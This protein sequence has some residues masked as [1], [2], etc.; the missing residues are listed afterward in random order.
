[1]SFLNTAV[2]GMIFILFCG[3]RYMVEAG[4]FARKNWVWIVLGLI[5]IFAFVLR[6]WGLGMPNLWFDESISA[7]NARDI[8][9]KGIPVFDS[10]ALYGGYYVFHYIMA[11]FYAV[12]GGDFSVRLISVLFG[13]ATVVLAFFIGKEFDNSSC[14]G[15]VTG[16]V[17]ALL[18]AV[19]YLEVVYSRQARFYQMFQFLFF[20][21]LLFLYKSKDEKKYA[22]LSCLSLI[23]LLD[24]HISG[25]V[26][27]PFFLVVFF[28][29][30]RKDEDWK[31]KDWILFVIPVLAGLWFG[32]GFFNLPFADSGSGLAGVNLESY[33]DVL[34][35]KLRAFFFISLI[36][37][38]F[39]IRKNLRMFL[40][41]VLPS[42]ILLIGLLFLKTYAIRYAYFSV[43]AVIILMAVLL[44]FIYNHSRVF[45]VIALVFILI[46]PSNLVYNDGFL[47]VIKPGIVETKS[48]TEPVLDY[49]NINSDALDLIME[50]KVVVMSTPGFYWYIKKPDYAIPFSLNGLANG[51]AI[52]D[53]KDVYSGASLFDLNNTDAGG[54]VF[55]EDYFGYSKLPSSVR[56]KVDALKAG[57]KQVQQTDFLKVFDC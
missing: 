31:G 54:F 43:F 20:L 40:L 35:A 23:L 37:I 39:A 4:V 48:I 16:L 15:Y 22:W 13:L 11:G 14:K 53:N 56:E 7:L 55:V 32:R 30:Y 6:I 12:F 27:I 10:G 46:Y 9:E 38:P 57:C 24:T 44:S 29:Q 49:K 25:L 51:F 28:L 42:L 33:S 19:F 45:F 17:A 18:S 50:N 3:L 8:L 5:L 21:T 41:I 34:F 1:M 36:G 47:T 2:S 52:Y 26:I